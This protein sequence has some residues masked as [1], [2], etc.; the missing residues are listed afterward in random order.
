MSYGE[1][2]HLY[3]PWAMKQI[4][5]CTAHDAWGWICSDVLYNPWCM[6]YM[7]CL[8]H[9]A[10]HVPWSSYTVVQSICHGVNIL[11][12]NPCSM[13][14]QSFQ[15]CCTIHGTWV[16]IYCPINCTIHVLWSSCTVVQSICHGVNI[17][18]CNPCSMGSW[19]FQMCCTIH[20]AWEDIPLYNPWS[21]GYVGYLTHCTIHVL[22]G[23][24]TV[25]Q[26]MVHGRIILLDVLY[27]PCSM[28]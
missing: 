10:I 13:G 15:M 16:Y 20:I 1:V 5:H 26:L 19:S 21:M 18:L 12:C 7:Y 22:W 28:G 11:L 14:S 17:L 4:Y 25:V 3:N 23:R 8:S 24:Y 27:S 6:G 2:I 9:C